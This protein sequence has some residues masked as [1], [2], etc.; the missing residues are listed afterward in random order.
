MHTGC[1]RRHSRHHH[2]RGRRSCWTGPLRSLWRCEGLTA[3]PSRI[4][5]WLRERSQGRRRTRLFVTW[6]SPS[7]FGVLLLVPHSADSCGRF[8]L[9]RGQSCDSPRNRP[10]MSL[11]SGNT[12]VP[13]PGSLAPLPCL[14][15]PLT[16]GVEW[17]ITYRK[18]EA[19]QIA[20]IREFGVG[21]FTAMLYPH[22][23]G[24]G[25]VAQQLGRGLRRP[26]SGLSAHINS[27]PRVGCCGLRPAGHRGGGTC[28]QGACAGGDVTR[29]ANSSTLHGGCWPRPGSPW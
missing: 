5:P 3:R 24:H 16:G 11:T 2:R 7:V 17:P 8:H 12:C 25:A 19:E 6:I 22:K 29:R 28:L 26:H 10:A 4:R 1:R 18:E 23:P 21:R 9:G 15:R 27:L 13:V 20:L 14:R